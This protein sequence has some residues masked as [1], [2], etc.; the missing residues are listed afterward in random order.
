MT[1]RD[2]PMPR[3]AGHLIEYSLDEELTLY[4]PRAEVVHILNLTAA[5]V[6]E[7]SDGTQQVSDIAAKLAGLYGLEPGAVEEDVQD[8]LGQFRQAGLLH[9]IVRATGAG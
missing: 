2:D 7:L 8:I 1:L 9:G 6:W 3:H 4:D 5:G